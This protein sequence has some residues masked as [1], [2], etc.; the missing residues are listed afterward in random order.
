MYLKLG[1][2]FERDNAKLIKTNH[3][4]CW[5]KENNFWPNVILFAIRQIYAVGNRRS[6]W[7]ASFCPE[8]NADDS[9]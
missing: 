8:N 7:S 2:Q 1:D 5:L 3:R 6:D 9:S 4:F